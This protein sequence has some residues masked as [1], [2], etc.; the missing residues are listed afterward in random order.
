[1]TS[2]TNLLVS[3]WLKTTKVHLA[4]ILLDFHSG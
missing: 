3:S 4:L 2:V 1:M